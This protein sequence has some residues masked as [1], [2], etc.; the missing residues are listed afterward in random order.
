VRII[1][2]KYKPKVKIVPKKPVSPKRVVKKVIPPVSPVSNPIQY[3]GNVTLNGLHIGKKVQTGGDQIGKNTKRNRGNSCF[4][5]AVE[6]A[7]KIQDPNL[8]FNYEDVL[9]KVINEINGPNFNP[10]RQDIVE[11]MSE[12]PA[13]NNYSANNVELCVRDFF[14]GNLAT[15]DSSIALIARACN[16][17]IKLITNTPFTSYET[18]F[19]PAQARSVTIVLDADSTGGHYS[20]VDTRP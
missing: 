2:K 8:S 11:F 3:I 13:V 14:N 5:L 16:V 1:P 15:A 4:F 9:E 6:Q 12:Y 17:S 7:L 19:N 18:I 10:A 20:T